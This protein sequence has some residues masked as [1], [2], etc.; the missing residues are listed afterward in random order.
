MSWAFREEKID[1]RA[2]EVWMARV[3]RRQPLDAVMWRGELSESAAA[4]DLHENGWDSLPPDGMWGDEAEI[5][6]WVRAHLDI[7]ADWRPVLEVRPQHCEVLGW[8]DGRPLQAFDAFH[9]TAPLPKQSGAAHVVALEAYCGLPLP[10]L[11]PDAPPPGPVVRGLASLALLDVVEETEALARDLR[12][13]LDTARQLDA[14]S[15]RRHCILALL[16]QAVDQLDFRRGIGDEQFHASAAVAHNFLQQNLFAEED[17]PRYR[18]T[19][20]AVGHAHIDTAWLWRIEHT[21]RKCLRTFTT[22][23]ALMERYPEYIFTCSQ[24]QQ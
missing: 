3:R 22:A 20:Y 14:G 4:V 19:L 12:F 23:L 24:A 2:R 11:R 15:P 18:P 21:R 5:T 10:N 9:H 8:L 6:V 7:P 13:A 1:A 16:D 17:T